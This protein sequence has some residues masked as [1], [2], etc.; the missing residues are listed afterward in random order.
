M[1]KVQKRQAEELVRQMEEAHDQ[2]KKFIEQGS[3]PSA[4]ELL[5]ECQNG[6]IALGTLI[7]QTEGEGHPTVL[8]LEEYCELIYQIHED[9]AGNKDINAD[10]IYKLLRRKL[11]KVENSVKNDIRIK[12]VA[13]F[14]P[15]KASMWDS[16]ESVWEAADEDADCDAYVIPIP[17]Y[18]R[19]PDR[20]FGEMH[21]EGDQYPD[22][23]PITK[24][25]E[26]DF[27]AHRPDMIY[28]HNPYDNYNLVTSV[29]P[30]FYTDNLKKFTDCLVYIPYYMTAGGM[31]KAQELIPPYMNIDYFVI[32]S[33]KF[34]EHFDECIPDEKFLPFGSPKA[35]RVIRKCQNPPTPPKEWQEKM[36]GKTVYFYNTSL[37]G[38]LED[39]DSFLKK[40]QYVFSCFEGRDDVC[41][42]WRPHPLLDT[43]FQSMRP[44]HWTL[45]QELKKYYLENE[46]GIFD[47]NADIED[48]IALSD[49]YIGDSGTSVTALFGVAGKPVFI[50]D[51]DI[52]SE[53]DGE[54]WRKRVRIQIQLQ[55]RFAISQSNQLYVSEPFQ[56][57]YKYFCDLSDDF[58]SRPYSNVHEIDGK[59]Y[60]CPLN[61]QSIIVVGSQG[62]EK[63][64]EL[65]KK[66]VEGRTFVDTWPYDRFLILLP[67][68]YPALVRFDTVSGEIKYFDKHVNVYVRNYKDR[69]IAGG[70]WV[71]E[72]ILYIA[73][74]I[75]NKMY[76]L[77]IESGE[78]QIVEL[79]IQSRCGCTALV[80][81]M[82]D[83]WLLPRNGKVIVRWNLLTGKARE[84]ADFPD[85]FACVNPEDNSIC[86]D[87]PFSMLEFHEDNIYFTPLWANMCLKLNIHTGTFEQWY[88]PFKT[89]DNRDIY[90]FCWHLPEENRDKSR[91]YSPSSGRLYEIDV[92]SG[93]YREI[94]IHIDMESLQQHEKRFGRY[95]EN[96]GYV[97][98]ESCF[99]TLSSFIDGEI[100]DHTFDQ[101]RQRKVYE[102]I[103]ANCDGECGK[104]VYDFIKKKIL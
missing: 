71:Y 47:T 54:S 94:A 35:D 104:K 88:L 89:M 14:L 45:F 87:N 13:V 44:Q 58:V 19:N 79:P 11:I 34:R 81:Y 84:Y 59:K 100:I 2:I 7:E 70:S 57:D 21:Y 36:A 85:G 40:M 82:G 20:S 67:L 46:I 10:K 56:Y 28:I 91:V 103:V 9:L 52:H 22:Y 1:R 55:G 6:G 95:A 49:V 75:D 68:N 29:H 73:S 86:E 77:N 74:P 48:S 26:F 30:F 25:D 60:V 90:C 32:Q 18:D 80:E 92:E 41:I 93:V 50:L 72:G 5:E 42:L 98:A 17:Y 69:K 4:T 61:A 15:Y 53:P 65:D 99:N 39:T 12:L 24:Y 83:L 23:V 102:E 31:N 63:I 51:K 38:M 43:T 96:L 8:V 16:L 64:I 97:C 101:S 33:P 62:V 3:I 66:V 37:S 27:G 78:E 76:Q